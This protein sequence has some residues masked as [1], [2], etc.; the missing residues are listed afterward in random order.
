MNKFFKKHWLAIKGIEQHSKD[1]WAFLVVSTWAIAFTL[2]T[3]AGWLIFV[4]WLDLHKVWLVPF[5]PLFIP[6]SALFV[7]YRASITKLREH[8]KDSLRSQG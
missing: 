8:A 4:Y 2:Y 1:A 6:I 7:G 3:L 5:V